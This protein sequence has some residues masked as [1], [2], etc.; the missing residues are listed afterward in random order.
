MKKPKV[1]H[2]PRRL[3]ARPLLIAAAITLTTLSGCEGV[4]G[5]L[6]NYADMSAPDAAP[7]HDLGLASRD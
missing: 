4:N 2:R 3:R 6:P 7:P 5:T 1:K